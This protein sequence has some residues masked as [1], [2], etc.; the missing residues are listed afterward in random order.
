MAIETRM[1]Q[2]D[3]AVHHP[4][5]GTFVVVGVALEASA[6]GQ[7]LEPWH[8]CRLPVQFSLWEPVPE[9]GHPGLGVQNP[10]AKPLKIVRYEQTSLG[11]LESVT[12]LGGRSDTNSGERCHH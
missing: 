8:A 10:A 5:G 1:L 4:D 11:S 6:P 7:A 2:V 12:S 9:A 3:P